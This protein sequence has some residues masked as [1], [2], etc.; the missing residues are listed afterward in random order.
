VDGWRGQLDLLHRGSCDR[1]DG[2]RGLFHLAARSTA[3]GDQEPGG[4]RETQGRKVLG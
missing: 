3:R 4:G 1:L 2:G